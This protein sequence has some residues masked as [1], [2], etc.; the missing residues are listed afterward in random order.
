MALHH[1]LAGLVELGEGRATVTAPDGSRLVMYW[2][3]R[4][5]AASVVRK[6]LDDPLLTESWGD[7][8]TRITLTVRCPG[9]QGRLTVRWLIVDGAD[10]AGKNELSGLA[11]HS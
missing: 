6:E 5:A 10:E 11:Q 8:L 3:P 1:V 7:H 4:D 9:A 2:N